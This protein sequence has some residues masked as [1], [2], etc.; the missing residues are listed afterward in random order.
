MELSKAYNPK[1]VEER[2]YK[3]WLKSGF[4]NPDNLPGKRTKP[5]SIVL[6]PPNVTGQLHMGHALNATMQDIIIR[7]KRMQGYLTL[8]LPGT[9]HAGIAT[10]N[11]VEKKLKKEGKTRFDVGKEGLI[12]EIWEWKEKYG[13]II[14][15]QF[16]RIGSSCD[17][18]RTRFT[19][20]DDYRKSVKQ[21]FLK[22]QKAGLIY[23]GERVINW[24]TRCQS[25]LSDVELE[26]K[27]EETKLYYL[28]Y[29]L[30]NGGYISTATTRPETMLGDMAL[31][32]N[33]ADKRYKK[34]IGES[35][36]LPITNIEIP[37]VKDLLVDPKFGT[38]VV[39]VTPA[40]DITD[41]QIS[42]N[43]NLKMKKVIDEDRKMT[44]NIPKRFIG[45][46][47]K[48]ARE[49][50]IKELEKQNLIEKIEKHV[51]RVPYC[52]RCKTRIES[53]PSKQWFVNQTKLAS[54]AKKEVKEG[55]IKF[56]PKRFE[57]PFFAWIDNIR[58]WCISR[59][60]W[61]G[62]KIPIKGE[63]DVLDTWFSS[64]LWPFA[65][66]GWPKKT[67]DL[68]KFYPTAVLSTAKDIINFWVLRMIFSG[69]FF[70][71]KAPFS[72]VFIHPMILATDGTKMSKSVGNVIN[73]I[74]LIEKYG[75]DATRLSLCWGVT[76]NQDMRF[77][78]DNVI[79]GQ[80]FCNKIWNATR[81]ILMQAEKESIETKKISLNIKRKN[82]KIIKQLEVIIKSTDKNIDNFEFGKTIRDL[83]DFFWHTFCDKYIEKAK[84]QIQTATTKKEKEKIIQT[85]LYVL[86]NSLKILHPFIPFI[87][88]E[89]YQ[90]LPIKNKQKSLM[91]EKW[92]K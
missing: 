52:S 74:D 44:G 48:K 54:L 18:S 72:T 20:D 29:K 41:Y 34:L 57:K 36:I 65:T 53:I 25:S 9:D 50:I 39:K 15:N 63:E 88:E 90:T 91:I 66:L 75:A 31:A 60:I 12:E 58:D 32:V 79:M 10:Q 80:K 89:I 11:V 45:L 71:E 7:R 23:K 92:P 81:F 6:P 70:M 13:S 46:S 68:K 83:Y 1:N 82:E 8:W 3:L 55:R 62:H 85:L 87:T 47:V 5:Y 17:W 26:H 76:G 51:H 37:I 35:A 73:P 30:V 22:Y 56:T 28:K 2:I 49:K 16:K 21:A 64:A 4:F 59:Q 61:W 27:E 69:I 14:L 19:M 86:I 78:E 77:S 84:K 43:S 40:H 33:P 24:C 38:G 42:L 67:K